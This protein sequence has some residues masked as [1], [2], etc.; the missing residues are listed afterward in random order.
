MNLKQAAILFV[1]DEAFL[2]ESMGQWLEQKAGRA[3][4]AE[5]GEAALKILSE[6]R[7]DLVVSDVHMPVMDGVALIRELRDAEPRPRIILVTGF[8]DLT[9]R[10]AYDMGVDAIV[11]KPI[12]RSELLCA[13]KQSLAE[14]EE[15]WERTPANA[16][17]MK[18][19]A[20]F[21]SFETAL[22]QNR[23]AFG[24]RGF[25]IEAHGDLREGPVDFAIAFQNDA[26]TLS[27]QGVVRWISSQEEQAGIEITCLGAA[28]RP[29]AL[30]LIKRTATISYIPRSPVVIRSPAKKVA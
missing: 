1:E 13:I 19:K 18:L 27:G 3:F 15:L 8:S 25:C 11:E 16:P 23:I 12:D 7:V 26:R 4:C 29:W 28:C 9:L 10:E 30:D 24:R 21:K 17:E 22:K 20:A 6:N 2:R 5:H 14:P